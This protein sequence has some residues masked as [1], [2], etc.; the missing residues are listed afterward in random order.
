MNKLKTDILQQLRQSGSRPVSGERLAEQ[1]SVTRAAVWKSIAALKRDGYRIEG[2][3][4]A[5]YRLLPSDVADGAELSRLLE[6]SGFP[7]VG[8]RIAA[9]LPSTNSFAERLLGEDFALPFLVLAE[10][11]TAGRARRGER[12]P[13]EPGGMYMS[14]AF[15]PGPVSSFQDLAGAVYSLVRSVIGGELRENAVFSGKEKSCGMLVEY[16]ADPDG[17]RACIAGIGVYPEVLA[18]D[19]RV[20]FPSRIELCAAIAAAILEKFPPAPPDR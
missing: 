4:R 3:P 9:T 6:L 5:G 7:G 16:V 2:V 12:F 17:I 19:V 13:S 15:R 1:F 14:L 8:I 11:Q 20:K 18:P 10:R